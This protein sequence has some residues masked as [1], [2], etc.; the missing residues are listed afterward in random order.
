[1]HKKPKNTKE[2]YAYLIKLIDNRG[3][4][5][6][7][8]VGY[9]NN[10]NRRFD[11]LEYKYDCRVEII[12]FWQFNRKEIALDMENFM[13]MEL[14]DKKGSV[15]IPQ[16]RFQ[17]IKIDISDLNKFNREAIFLADHYKRH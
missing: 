11:E 3:R 10:L 12:T 1:M 8:K 6:Y 4:T 16:D 9:T 2:H 15:Y 14:Q 7:T 17:R 13:R 5:K